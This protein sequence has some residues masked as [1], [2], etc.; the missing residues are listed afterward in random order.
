MLWITWKCDACWTVAYPCMP[1]CVCA[2]CEF[3][4]GLFKSVYLCLSYW[5]PFLFGDIVKFTR[6]HTATFEFFKIVQCDA[7]YTLLKHFHKWHY[8]YTLTGNLI[9]SVGHAY[10]LLPHSYPFLFQQK[11]WKWEIEISKI[12][13]GVLLHYF[14]RCRHRCDRFSTDG[15][16]KLK[17][18]HGCKH[19]TLNVS[20]GFLCWKHEVWKEKQL[21][22]RWK[23]E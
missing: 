16:L 17:F 11:T 3:A 4:L 22:H 8:L 10:G 5:F 14:L 1:F 7:F 23:Y 2:V 19:D 12:W 18:V 15:N 20:R 6:R 13:K 21:F 9:C